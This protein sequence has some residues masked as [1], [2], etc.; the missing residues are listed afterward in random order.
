VRLIE[1]GSSAAVVTAAVM[2]VADSFP[3]EVR[4]EKQETPNP[5]SDAKG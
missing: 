1:L 4:E 3:D 2:Y 5:N